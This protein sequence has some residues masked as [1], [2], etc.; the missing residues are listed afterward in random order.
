MGA[1]CA[2][3]EQLV[4]WELRYQRFSDQWDFYSGVVGILF[5]VV[6]EFQVGAIRILSGHDGDM[7]TERNTQ[8]HC[9][10]I[11]TSTG[12]PYRLC[13]HRDDISRT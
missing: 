13:A 2:I 4:C 6:H 1:T 5:S 7:L 3:A 12:F 9:R 10:Y 11:R 8:Y